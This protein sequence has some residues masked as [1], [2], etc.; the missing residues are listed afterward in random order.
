M[1]TFHK[2]AVFSLAHIQT[3]GTPAAHR[4]SRCNICN[5]TA[6]AAAAA[7]IKC[8][9][10]PAVQA[11]RWFT[12]LTSSSSGGER[13][14]FSHGL[15]NLFLRWVAAGL[16]DRIAVPSKRCLSATLFL[17][18]ERCGETTKIQ[19]KFKALKKLRST[20]LTSR[21]A[22]ECV[23]RLHVTVGLCSKAKTAAGTQI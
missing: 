1:W 5:P 4:A 2:S 21:K 11:P 16:F 8:P 14:T 6:A 10:P 22:C 17:L 3:S 18:S 15:S 23:W 7:I 9:P 19:A 20:I 13:D 12:L